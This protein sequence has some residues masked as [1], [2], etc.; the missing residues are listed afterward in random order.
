M[1][2]MQQD[3]LVQVF[4]MQQYGPWGLLFPFSLHFILL[5]SILCTSSHNIV[6]TRHDVNLVN[7]SHKHASSSHSTNGGRSGMLG[8]ATPQTPLLHSDN[9]RGIRAASTT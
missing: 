4:E 7:F 1:D 9:V 6:N 3:T 5:V 2:K 8:H